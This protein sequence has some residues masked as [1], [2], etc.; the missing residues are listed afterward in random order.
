[1]KV[2]KTFVS[3]KMTRTISLKYEDALKELEEIFV[4]C[5]KEKI[6][7]KLDRGVKLG[8]GRGTTYQINVAKKYTEENSKEI[9]EK[10]E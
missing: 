5:P 2:K 7:E 4:D 8:N 6:K 9:G 10:N 1:M 3:R